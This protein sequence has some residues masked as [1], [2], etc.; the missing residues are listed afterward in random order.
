MAAQAQ[1]NRFAALDLGAVGPPDGGAAGHE[2]DSSVGSN[3]EP[4]RTSI[5]AP[6]AAELQSRYLLLQV[7]CLR[8]EELRRQSKTAMRGS[9]PGR[10]T[11]AAE[12]LRTAY[13]LL[14]QVMWSSECIE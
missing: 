6:A 11:L 9:T 7:R 1:S 2:S 14:E 10:W 13:E 3:D 12:L 4:Q 5:W 8:S